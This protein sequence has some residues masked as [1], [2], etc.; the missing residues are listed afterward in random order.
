MGLERR[1]FQ[2][3]AGSGPTREIFQPTAGAEQRSRA[4]P[5]RS[6]FQLAA[7]PCRI[8]VLLF[9]PTAG[10]AYPGNY[11]YAQ[12][13]LKNVFVSS[14]ARSFTRSPQLVGKTSTVGW[15]EARSWLE[16]GPQRT[17]RCIPQLT[18]MK[19]A[20]GWKTYRSGLE[21]NRIYSLS[22]QASTGCQRFLTCFTGS[23]S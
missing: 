2:S 4:I 11:P 15:K 17:G 16:T 10:K 14:G 19:S 18:G 13:A 22:M 5:P 23:V 7:G 1:N 20:V 3:T 9:H 21:K 12:R 8:A 6:F